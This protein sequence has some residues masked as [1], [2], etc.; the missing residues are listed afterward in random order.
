MP[1]LNGETRIDLVLS[2]LNVRVACQ[3]FVATP[4]GLEV[5]NLLRILEAG[6][7]SVFLVSD[8]TVRRR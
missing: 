8:A 5:T 7:D 4:K 1:V 2:L 6:Y 3:I